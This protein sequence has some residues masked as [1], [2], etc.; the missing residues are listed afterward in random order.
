M[1]LVTRGVFF[2]KYKTARLRFDSYSS[3]GASV[4]EVDEELLR[5]SP[6][7]LMELPLGQKSTNIDE[8]G[9]S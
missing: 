8:S 1:A 9:I 6:R 4:S 2:C 5:R 3:T 7:T